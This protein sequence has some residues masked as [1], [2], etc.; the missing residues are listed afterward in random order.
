MK[1]VSV[2]ICHFYW[3]PLKTG[4]FSAQRNGAQ[5]STQRKGYIFLLTEQVLTTKLWLT[6]RLT[7]KTRVWTLLVWTA[8]R[9]RKTLLHKRV[10]S[11]I[12]VNA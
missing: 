4:F 5:R 3:Y 11:K 6:A 9:H 12:S 8:K 10:R 2:W 1:G 7:A